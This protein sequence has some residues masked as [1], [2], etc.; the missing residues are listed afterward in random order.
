[1]NEGDRGGS[2]IDSANVSVN[3]Q[4]VSDDDDDDDD[5]ANVNVGQVRQQV[6]LHEISTQQFRYRGESVSSDAV[7][8]LKAISAGLIGPLNSLRYSYRKLDREL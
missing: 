5:D 1:V 2:K 4:E 3:V 6:Q 8:A 7:A